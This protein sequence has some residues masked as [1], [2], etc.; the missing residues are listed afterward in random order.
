MILTGNFGCPFF[1]EKMNAAGRQKP[2]AFV[3]M[4]ADKVGVE[5]LD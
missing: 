2:A 1:C 4:G 5:W 3:V